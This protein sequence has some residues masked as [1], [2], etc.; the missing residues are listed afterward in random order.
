MRT[1]LS[2]EVQGA[3][4]HVQGAHPATRAMWS[5]GLSRMS[6]SFILQPTNGLW[7]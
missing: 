3:G 1:A 5:C 6:S 2:Q 4:E 7:N